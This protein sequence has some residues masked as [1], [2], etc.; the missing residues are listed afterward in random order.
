VS[1]YAHPFIGSESGPSPARYVEVD[2]LRAAEALFASLSGGGRVTVPFRRQFSGEHYGNFT[3]RFG[4]RG[5]T[6]G[7]RPEVES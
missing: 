4:G 2:E 1:F 5:R 7:L 6:S 3:D